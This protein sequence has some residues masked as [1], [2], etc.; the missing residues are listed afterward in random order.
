GAPLSPQLTGAVD[1]TRQRFSRN[2]LIPPPFGGQWRWQNQALLNFSYEFDFWGKNAAAYAAALGQAKAA[3]VDAYA[4][5]LVLA[6]GIARAYVQLAHGFDQL[7]L[8]RELVA[9]REKTLA[10]VSERLAAGLDSRVELKQA[11]AALPEA[12]Q[13][14]AQ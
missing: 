5:R 2:A 9:Q 6:S 1:A 3:E 11:E 7:E 12:R 8:A 10:L 4:A 14:V 13:R